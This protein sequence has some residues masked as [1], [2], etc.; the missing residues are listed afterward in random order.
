MLKIFISLFFL[1]VGL[2]AANQVFDAPSLVEANYKALFKTVE[3][4]PFKGVDPDPEKK[5]QDPAIWKNYLQMN[6]NFEPAKDIK[7]QISGILGKSLD[8][9][10]PKT[11]EAAPRVEAH[12]T[13]IAPPEYNNVLYKFISMDEINRIALKLEIQHSYF[14]ILGVGSSSACLDDQGKASEDGTLEETFYLV[15]DSINLKNIRRAVYQQ[16]Y[17]NAQ[18]DPKLEEKIEELEK[19]DP[20]FYQPHITLGYTFKDLHYGSHGAIKDCDSL[21]DR[22]ILN[23]SVR[24]QDRHYQ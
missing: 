2:I 23:E 1:P 14:E 15:V 3:F 5:Q 16:A 22:F 10:N 11:K 13:V 18:Y 9:Y 12:I 20:D 17:M 6:I 7:N 19:F 4:I 21:D 8:G 24:C